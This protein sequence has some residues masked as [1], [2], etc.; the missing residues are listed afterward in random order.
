MAAPAQKGRLRAA[1]A[2]APQPCL[3]VNFFCE[4]FNFLVEKG[5]QVVHMCMYCISKGLDTEGEHS[6]KICYTGLKRN[7]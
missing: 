6:L 1:P 4:A 2:P 7:C 5:L 3:K